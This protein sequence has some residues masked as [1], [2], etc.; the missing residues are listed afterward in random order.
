MDPAF[1][2]RDGRVELAVASLTRHLLALGLPLALLGLGDALAA[3]PAGVGVAA[4][5]FGAG[6]ALALIAALDAARAVIARAV[7]QVPALIDLL[8]LPF[9][10]LLLAAIAPALALALALLLGI[11]VAALPLARRRLAP[12]RADR[13]AALIRRDRI[14]RAALVD[15]VG[16]EA[17]GLGPALARALRPAGRAAAA[18][19][20]RFGRGVVLADLLRA[21]LGWAALL[22]LLGLGAPRLADGR[23]DPVAFAAALLLAGQALRLLGAALTAPP[24]AA[25]EEAAREAEEGEGAE[26]GADLAACLP[27]LLDALGWQGDRRR[28]AMLLPAGRLDFAAL[29]EG[30]ARLG[31]VLRAEHWRDQ[32]LEALPP[33]G[34]PALALSPGRPPLLVLPPAVPGGMPRALGPDGAE[35]PDPGRL[36][37]SGPVWR[38]RPA[39]PAAVPPGWRV[40]L[41]P[42]WLPLLALSLLLGALDLAPVVAVAAALAGAGTA[43]AEVSDAV[44]LSGLGLAA[45]AALAARALRGALLVRLGARLDAL[46]AEAAAAPPAPW[47]GRDG[48]RRRIAAALAWRHDL[49]RLGASLVDRPGAALAA[50]VALPLPLAALAVAGGAAAVLPALAGLGLLLLAG[51]VLAP[52]TLPGRGLRPRL[53]ALA[54]LPEPLGGLI[55]SAALVAAAAGILAGGG[56]LARAVAVALLVWI[57]LAAPRRLL[58]A[59]PALAPAF[60]ALRRLAPLSPLPPPA[61]RPGRPPVPAPIE[62]DRVD[63]R[64]VP[65]AP[66]VLRDFSLSIAPREVLVVAGPPRAGSSTLLRL[67]AGRQPAES[68]AVRHDGLD[69]AQLAPDEVRARVLLVVAGGHPGFGTVQA[70]LAAADPEAGPAVLRAA[71]EQVGL[72]DEIAALPRRLDTAM[73]TVTLPP[74]F[75]FRLALAAALL[76]APPALLIDLGAER[77]DPAGERALAAVIGRFRDQ[78][79]LVLVSTRPSHWRLADRVLL[80]ERGTVRYLGPP[81]AID[82]VLAAKVT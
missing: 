23:L 25:R 73:E 69:L 48:A 78:S 21:G 7:G 10:P 55:A 59:L 50:L 68:G 80:L 81:D 66:P 58:A 22:A 70:A 20:G 12:A 46:A 3:G 82:S 31:F 47:A 38:I 52:L 5:L 54:V 76:E 2:G 30:L 9:Y 39:D 77:L 17:Q 44:L 56:G 60:A 42:L 65:W 1:H 63:A 75:G 36:R 35:R 18:A 13:A 33:G 61:S 45:L 72:W 32:P 67:I 37:L 11:G 26:E 79:T 57:A 51:L 8:F 15:P 28:L 74:G 64:A 29:R 53:G 43:L 49:D 24:V 27:P 14:L 16:L 41:R 4:P 62:L 34:A 71:C 19:L 6:L 40:R